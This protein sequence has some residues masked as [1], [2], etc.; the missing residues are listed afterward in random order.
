MSAECTSII[1]ERPRVQQRRPTI[2][3][4]DEGYAS[5][6]RGWAIRFI[7]HVVLRSQDLRMNPV[8]CP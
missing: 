5:R 3:E 1:G 7:T 2:G 8:F 4:P 6:Q